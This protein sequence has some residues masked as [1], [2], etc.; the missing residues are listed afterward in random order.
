[1]VS[2]FKRSRALG[3]VGLA[4]A[5][6]LSVSFVGASPA[7]ANCLGVGDTANEMRGGWDSGT[8]WGYAG[9]HRNTCDNDGYESAY[10][11]DPLTDGSCVW[12]SYVDV[13]FSGT[14]ATSCD[15]FGLNYAYIDATP[16]G[17]YVNLCR[18]QG[19]NGWLPNYGY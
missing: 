15:E 14:M 13:T 1:V 10:I 7:S 3:L 11:S 9:S 17:S 2:S 5:S 4:I 6:C 12:V 18:A 8:V 19:C 16:V